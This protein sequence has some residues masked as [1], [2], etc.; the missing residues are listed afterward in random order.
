VTIPD[1]ARGDHERKPNEEPRGSDSG[2]RGQGGKKKKKKKNFHPKRTGQGVIEMETKKA[3]INTNLMREEN[4]QIIVWAMDAGWLVKE[5]EKSRAHK[6]GQYRT[7]TS[8]GGENN[9]IGGRR[10]LGTLKLKTPCTWPS[11][12]KSVWEKSSP[13]YICKSKPL[14]IRSISITEGGRIKEGTRQHRKTKGCSGKFLK[15]LKPLSKRR[16]KESGEEKDSRAG[17]RG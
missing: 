6:Q 17:I 16:W 9:S 8:P 15:A 14:S 5:V 12:Q 10:V 2:A 3:D 4:F 1:P 11:P 13:H 7:T